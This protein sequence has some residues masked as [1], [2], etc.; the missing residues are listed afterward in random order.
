MKYEK[1]LFLDIDGVLNSGRTAYAFGKYPHGCDPEQRGYFDH[2]AIQLIKNLIAET[3]TNIVLSSSWR[4]IHDLDDISW[5]L[6]FP[7]VD[8]TPTSDYGHRGNEIHAWMIAHGTPTKWAIVDDDKDMRDDQLQNFVRTTY[9]NGL[10]LDNYKALLRL[11][12]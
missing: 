10:S 8:K 5:L 4:K 7:V 1:V 2:V 6:G 9:K 11:L 3:G 12:K